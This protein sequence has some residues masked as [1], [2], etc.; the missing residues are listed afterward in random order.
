MTAKLSA[1]RVVNRILMAMAYNRET[2]KD[3]V[4]EYIGGALLEFY[5]A[6]LARKIGKTKWIQ[7]WETEVRHLL[8]LGLM[9][10][11][12]HEIRGFKD[13]Q[14]AIN[15]VMLY[16]KTKDVSYRRSAEYIIKK[17][18][19]LSELR[20]TIEDKDTIEFWNRVQEVVDIATQ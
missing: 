3:K 6:K 18:Y 14:K 15:E 4:E 2:F 1:D 9:R 19:E 8:H 13:R 10:V 16:I 17:D 20:K 5:K 12:R 7:H 11:V